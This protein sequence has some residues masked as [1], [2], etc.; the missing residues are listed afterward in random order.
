[1]SD[2]WLFFLG[3]MFIIVPLWLPKGVIGLFQ[4]LRNKQ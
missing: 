3:A 2:Y 1:L 4:R